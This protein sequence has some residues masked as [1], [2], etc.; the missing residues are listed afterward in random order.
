MVKSPNI[1]T[2]T[3]ESKFTVIENTHIDPY[4]ETLSR[5]GKL[6]PILGNLETN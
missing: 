2:R 1:R 4:T 6:R 3:G 5:A